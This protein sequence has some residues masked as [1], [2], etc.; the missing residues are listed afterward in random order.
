MW[1]NITVK[2]LGLSLYIINEDHLFL[3]TT[4][5][6]CLVS[7]LD[8]H[9]FGFFI[10]FNKIWFLY[11]M[12]SSLLYMWPLIIWVK[13]LNYKNQMENSLNILVKNADSSSF[14]LSKNY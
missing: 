11:F 13:A 5:L 2:S 10:N 8:F 14:L 4:V 6:G 12:Y 1:N 9:Y 3:F 7:L